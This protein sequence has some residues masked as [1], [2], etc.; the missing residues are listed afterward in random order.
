MPPPN[1]HTSPA[2]KKRTFRWTVGQYGFSG[3]STSETPIAS[4]GLPASCGREAVAEGGS[5]IPATCE[6]FTPP[7][8]NRLP[9][10]MM[11][12]TPPPPSGR[13]QESL[14]K[15]FPSR[16]SRDETSAPCRAERDSSTRGVIRAS[17]ALDRPVADVFA[18]L[19]ALEADRLDHF[20]GSRGGA[21]YG[22]AER[23]HTQPPP[24]VGDR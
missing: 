7:R 10:S 24:A 18:V 5:C 22:M 1:H 12:L 23:R 19:H 16:A 15:D 13:F 20:V 9:P 17:C 6:R 4:H 2:A 8:S 14:T 3:C 21:A 11:R